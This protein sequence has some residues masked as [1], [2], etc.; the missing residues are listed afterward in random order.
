LPDVNVMGV[1]DDAGDPLRVHVETIVAVVGCAG[2][3][4]GRGRRAGGLSRW[5]IFRRSVGGA[6]GVAQ[7]PL[8][9]PGPVA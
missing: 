8:V 1:E 4:L 7:A 5:W 2:A 3:G 9:L 6:A